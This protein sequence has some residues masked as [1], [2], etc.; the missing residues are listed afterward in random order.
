MVEKFKQ[1][2]EKLK[3]KG[4]VSLFAV[5]KM[6]E[7]ADRWSI[8][9]SADWALEDRK[10]SFNEIF[11]IFTSVLNKEEWELIARIGLFDKN[12][13]I[14]KVFLQFKE[15]TEIKEVTQINGFTVYEAY[16]LA[17]SNV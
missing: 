6:D 5:I 11:D 3:E 8:A 9:I 13:H 17:S 10:K 2:L 14:A 16:I 4:E 1:I 15:G 7:L 12:D